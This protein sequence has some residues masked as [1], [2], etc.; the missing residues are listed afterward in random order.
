[1]GDCILFNPS[2]TDEEKPG[3]YRSGQ[4]GRTVNPLAYA[5]SG[6]NPLLPIS[7]HCKALITQVDENHGSTALRDSAMFRPSVVSLH[8]RASSFSPRIIHSCPF[9][10]SWECIQRKV[11]TNAQH[12]PTPLH[13]ERR[14]RHAGIWDRP[15]GPSE[16][17]GGLA[18]QPYPPGSCIPIRVPQ[19][20]H[21]R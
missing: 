6:S 20:I 17:C 9:L 7:L 19:R 11:W 16:T 10:C 18:R 3:R 12:C 8:R 15:A 14:G 21:P 5:F 13:H 2:S 1:M 4:T